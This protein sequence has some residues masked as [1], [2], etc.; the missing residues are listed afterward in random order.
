MHIYVHML[1]VLIDILQNWS[2]YYIHDSTSCFSCLTFHVQ[3]SSVHCFNDFIIAHGEGV[4]CFS[5][6]TLLIDI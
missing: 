1:G 6:I 5:I 2:G 4:L 3:I